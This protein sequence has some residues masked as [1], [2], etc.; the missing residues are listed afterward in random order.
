LYFRFRV[1]QSKAIQVACRYEHFEFWIAINDGFDDMIQF[2]QAYLPPRIVFQL[3]PV[4]TRSGNRHIMFG[5]IRLEVAFR[6]Q[7]DISDEFPSQLLLSGS[8]ND[9]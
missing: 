5:P 2:V 3:K 9:G 1:E 7:D 4:Y 6:V 8:G